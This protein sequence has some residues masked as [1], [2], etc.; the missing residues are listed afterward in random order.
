[1]PT[2]LRPDERIHEREPR[3]PR[4]LMDLLNEV[5]MPNNPTLKDG[6]GT[7]SWEAKGI[8]SYLHLSR[9]LHQ[10]H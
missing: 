4:N 7:L 6:R 2:I 10:L 9:K 5:R 8:T 1:M 3:L